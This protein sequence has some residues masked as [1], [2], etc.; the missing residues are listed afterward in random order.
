MTRLQAIRF[1][2]NFDHGSL[3]PIH[4]SIIIPRA[5]L[6]MVGQQNGLSKAAYT[7]IGRRT[8]LYYGSVET[9]CFPSPLYLHDLIRS[10]ILQLVQEKAFCGA[11]FLVCIRD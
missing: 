2:R 10:R 5:K 1:E 9:V 7:R 8:A 6:N 4:P 3:L 11:Q